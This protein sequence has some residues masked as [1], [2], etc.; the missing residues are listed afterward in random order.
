MTLSAP[1]SVFGILSFTPYSR[2]TGLPY[3]I[4][5][6]LKSSSL[7][8][9]GELIDL[10]GG[11]SKYPWASEDGNIT[12][13]ISLQFSQYEDFL[14][15]LFLGKAPTPIA[16]DTTGDVTALTNYK[17]TTAK[18]ATIG[19]ASVA[20]TASDEGDLK[21]G[22]YVVKVVSATTFDI[23][24]KSD[25]D[26]SRGNN[27]T[28]QDDLLKV[29]ATPLTVTTA[30]ANIIADLGITFT[31]GSGTIAMVTGDTATFEILPVHGGAMSVTIGSVADQVFPEFG[32]LVYAQKRGNQEMLEIDCFRCKAIGMPINFEQNNWSSAEVAIKVLYDS[33]QDGVFSIRHV[34][35][36]L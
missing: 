34:E 12:A 21:F 15:E 25:I 7:S 23:Y 36:T 17:G 30:G 11:S 31:G 16:A 1:R 3:G 14:F 13:E 9:K 20:I 2:T 27:A 33:A 29:T 19:I 22:K 24:L 5:K 28:Y 8:L 26:I 35:P 10:M 6:V 32:A 4:V 18:S